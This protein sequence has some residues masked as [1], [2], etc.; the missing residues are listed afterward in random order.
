MFSERPIERA[1]VNIHQVLEHVRRVA[2]TGFAAHLRVHEEYDP[3][4]PPVWG[5]RDQLV[6]ILLNLVKNAAEAVDA[7]AGEIHLST[8]FHHGVR[9]AIPGSRERCGTMALG[10]RRKCGRRCS[11]PSSP[12]SAAAKAWVLH[13]WPS[14]SPTSVA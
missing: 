8:A 13:W 14:W 11:S 7:K 12:P 6:Q 1:A 10:S 5:N 9:I 4:L 3:S 2:Q